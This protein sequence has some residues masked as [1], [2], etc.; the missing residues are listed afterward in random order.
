ALERNVVYAAGE[1]WLG[2]WQDRIEIKVDYSKVESTLTN[3]PALIHLSSSSGTNSAD[4]TEVFDE[5]KADSNRNKIAVTK[6]DGTTQC[7]VEIESW[8]DADEQ[9]WLWVRIPIVNFES[10]TILYLYYD[11]AQPDNTSYVGD[12][13]SI[14]AE[15]VWNSD[16]EGVWHL[17]GDYD[18]ATNEV[19]DSTSN[20][21]HGQGGGGI[22]SQAPTEVA[23]VI[24]GGQYFNGDSG[25]N[26]PNG[27]DQYIEIPDN[28]AFSV[29]TTGQ[30]M[31]EVWIDFTVTE[32]YCSDLNP[33]DANYLHALGKC[34]SANEEWILV[35][36]GSNGDNP[37]SIRTYIMNEH[38]GLGASADATREWEVGDKVHVYGWL[39]TTTKLIYQEVWYPGTN[40]TWVD[41][42]ENDYE[43]EGMYPS[44]T[45]SNLTIGGECQGSTSVEQW[46]EGTFDEFRVMNTNQTA[47]WRKANHY[48][49]VDELLYYGVGGSFNKKYENYIDD[50]NSAGIGNNVWLGQSFTPGTDHILKEVRWKLSGP[51][52]PAGNLNC[53]LYIADGNH[54]PTGSILSSGSR[55]VSSIDRIGGG[56]VIPITMSDY[57]LEANKEYCL[58]LC[59]PNTGSSVIYYMN[60]S[61][62]YDG[63]MWLYS[64]NNGSSWSTNSSRDMY[65]EEWGIS[66]TSTPTYF[67]DVNEDGQVNV[68]DLILIGQH[69]GES[70]QPGWIPEDVNEDGTVNV[71]DMILIGQNWTR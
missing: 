54:E 44:N 47:T 40:T 42:L 2:T 34:Q 49:Q 52:T 28:D 43:E 55:L 20:A 33:D 13:G 41:Y 39:D 35:I 61:G 10:D 23:S 11:S 58:V 5:L 66:S 22:A 60:T 21:N 70:G 57:E 37:Y 65:F 67:Y 25:S 63:G 45:A 51:T 36:G 71:L 56:W 4:L 24:G 68:L 27:D 69:R 38:G 18:G 26:P 50:N 32:F 48:T 53:Y 12:A 15:N 46:F 17:E 64:S 3:F 31:Y 30:L 6:S 7:Y 19:K 14:P 9:A 16:F 29:T 59:A 62:E 1:N 8:D